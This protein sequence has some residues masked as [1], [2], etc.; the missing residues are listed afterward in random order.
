MSGLTVAA[1]QP[2]ANPAFALP[3]NSP[4]LSPHLPSW[5]RKI[6]D[7]IACIWVRIKSF[8]IHSAEPRF[9]KQQALIQTYQEVALDRRETK[10]PFPYISTTSKIA[11]AYGVF[12][13][14]PNSTN[15]F[16]SMPKSLTENYI[17]SK[18][19]SIPAHLIERA[20]NRIFSHYSFGIKKTAAFIL[21]QGFIWVASMQLGR[22]LGYMYLAMITMN[23]LNLRNQIS[24]A[25]HLQQRNIIN[26]EQ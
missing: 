20:A 21:S 26:Y 14:I 3:S 18:C 4:L 2:M 11:M 19:A 25:S 8:F 10:A 24:Q 15:F 7:F 22:P 12:T 17:R 9:S 5:Q 1:G 16:I 13:L 6:I 23:G